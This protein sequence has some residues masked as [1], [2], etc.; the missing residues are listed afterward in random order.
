MA[1]SS[2]YAY[3]VIEELK[4]LI[5]DRLRRGRPIAEPETIGGC[6]SQMIGSLVAGGRINRI[7]S[8]LLMVDSDLSNIG[9]R[10]RFCSEV[11]T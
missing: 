7:E 8:Q 5:G 1:W 4:G 6:F 2:A 11:S 9:S 10:G 3:L